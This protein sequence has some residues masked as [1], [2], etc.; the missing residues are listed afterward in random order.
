MTNS[1]AIRAPTMLTGIALLALTACSPKLDVQT[2]EPRESNA[3]LA[4][5]RSE[6]QSLKALRLNYRNDP[7]SIRLDGLINLSKKRVVDVLGAPTFECN[8]DSVTGCTRRGDVVYSFYKLP[9]TAVGG[10]PELS[11]SFDSS[12]NCVRAEWVHSQ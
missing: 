12:D 8:S 1:T 9:E 5:I 6:I 3:T 2:P 11:L 7:S 4:A 10:G